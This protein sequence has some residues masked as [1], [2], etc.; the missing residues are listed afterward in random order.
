MTLVLEE[1]QGNPKDLSPEETLTT[2]RRSKVTLM[3]I[4]SRR[5]MSTPTTMV[6][7]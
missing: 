4:I 7:N 2:S 6:L 3:K 5:I 1:E